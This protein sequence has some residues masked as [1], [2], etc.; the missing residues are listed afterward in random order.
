MSQLSTIKAMGSNIENAP[1]EY[2]LREASAW[3]SGFEAGFD[4]AIS[5]NIATQFHEWVDDS[6]DYIKFV[7]HFFKK[8]HLLPTLEDDYEYFITHVYGNK[9]EGS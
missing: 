9:K 4:K 6:D 7:Q 3:A 1:Q 2:K 5:L 8:S